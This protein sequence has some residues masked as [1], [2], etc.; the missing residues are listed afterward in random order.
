MTWS[1]E[2]A[3]IFLESDLMDNR[4]KNDLNLY[5]LA[6]PRKLLELLGRPDRDI[7]LIH[8]AGT[9]GKGSTSNF[10]SD[11][12]AKRYLTGLHTSP[13]FYSYRE[14]ILINKEPITKKDF[15]E[16]LLRIKN[17]MDDPSFTHEGR[18]SQH[19]TGTIL[20]LT[21]FSR[22]N[23]QWA[24]IETGMG[25]TYDSTNIINPLVSVITP[26]SYDHVGVLGNTLS[27]IA[28][29]KAGIIK[30][31]GL[32][33]SA[34][35]EKESL[36]ILER[37]SLEMNA[38]LYV[39]GRDIFISERDGYFDVITPSGDACGLKISMSGD[40]QIQNASLAVS[41]IILLKNKYG[42][43]LSLKDIRQAVYRSKLPGRFET[44]Q[45]RPTI[46]LD[47]AHNE[48][49]LLKL[50]ENVSKLRYKECIVIFSLYGD[51]D[52]KKSIALLKIVADKVIVTGMINAMRE[53]NTSKIASELLEQR[54]R[55]NIFS[56]P[57][58]ALDE[59]KR[60]ASVEDLIVVTG[61]LQL[62]GEV[63]ALLKG[64]PKDFLDEVG[65]VP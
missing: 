63:R 49:A 22:K 61:S 50:T 35:Q 32:V 60:L 3:K 6:R 48:S 52:I 44:L 18:P 11:I 8:V 10:L 65:G 29:H 26:I 39:I 27:E 14:R 45:R 36:R 16:I 15:F 42:I 51:K 58:D 59:A 55:H 40:H 47:G 7:N 13:H 31:N 4:G 64:I 19:E 38:M 46:I 20:T 2:E 24:V 37:K 43:D 17:K 25:G 1:Y 12:L 34:S 5:S 33:I 23:V 53:I 30:K 21:A 56:Y 62:V 28:E 54:V 9:N 57:K 41:T